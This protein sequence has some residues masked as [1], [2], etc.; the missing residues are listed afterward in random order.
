M[1]HGRKSVLIT[2]GLG[3]I[4]SHLA[5]FLLQKGYDVAIYDNNTNGNNEDNIRACWNYPG[6]LFFLSDVRDKHALE[7]AM[8]KTNPD[9]VFHLAAKIHWEES[10]NYPVDAYEVS[11]LGT[12]RVLEAVREFRTPFMLYASSSEVYGSAQNIPMTELHPLNPQSPYAAGKVAGDRLCAGY[13][14]VYKTPVV[15]L[16]Q[17]NTYGPRQRPKGYSAVIPRFISRVVNEKPPIIFGDGTQTRDF[18]YIDDLL[19]AY[20]RIIE[21]LEKEPDKV[22]GKVMNFGTG[23]ETSINELAKMTI[24]IV[25][26]KLENVKIKKLQPVHGAKRPGEVHRFAADISL[27]KQLLSFT[28]KI[29]LR[30]GLTR[31]I[32]WYLKGHE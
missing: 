21:T 16:R 24:D 27:A 25:N 22:L 10:I 31:Y 12:M 7:S 4:G 1:A 30:E 29:S 14:N 26:E 19:D 3:F 11:A 13:W 9:F 8:N 32:D 23:K 20:K 15:V 5:E 2:G 17:F 6:F 18:H 28:P